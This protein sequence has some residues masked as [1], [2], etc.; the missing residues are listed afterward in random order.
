M[1]NFLPKERIEVQSVG[2]FGA[3]NLAK[4]ISGLMTATQGLAKTIN[5]SMV[6][7]SED[8]GKALA[9]DALIEWKR[10]ETSYNEAR[11]SMGQQFYESVDNQPSA[12]EQTSQ[13]LKM[14]M[15]QKLADVKEKLGS[16]SVAY[17]AFEDHFLLQGTNLTEN[18]KSELSKEHE[19]YAK[20]QLNQSAI[21]QAN[22]LGNDM[23]TENAIALRNST[24]YS[25][26]DDQF[27]KMF[28]DKINGE[29]INSNIDLRPYVIGKKQVDYKNAKNEF[30]KHF[31]SV[32]EMNDDGSITSKVS[33]L[34]QEDIARIKNSWDNRISSIQQANERND[35]FNLENI[36]V[37]Q[38]IKDFIPS[39]DITNDL[40]NINSTTSGLKDSLTA[41]VSSVKPED[42]YK[43][44]VT[45]QEAEN[46]KTDITNAYIVAQ[47]PE[48]VKRT[49]EDGFFRTNTGE[50]ISIDTKYVKSIVQKQYDIKL[51]E[52]VNNKDNP[53]ALK[54]I[55]QDI[56]N[57]QERSGVPSTSIHSMF[58][59][60]ASFSDR[61]IDSISSN[62]DMISLLRDNGYTYANDDVML[63]KD[64]VIKVKQIIDEGRKANKSD[65][66][67]KI[68]LNRFKNSTIASANANKNMDIGVVKN[69]VEKVLTNKNDREEFLKNWF[70]RKISIDNFVG[71]NESIKGGIGGVITP[72]SQ[73]LE[74]S[75]IDYDKTDKDSIVNALAKVSMP[76][77]QSTI[78]LLGDDYTFSL[79]KVENNQLRT[80]PVYTN[81]IVD[82]ANEQ[83]GFSG[84]KAL[85]AKNVSFEYQYDHL[86]QETY[87]NVYKKNDSGLIEPNPI[88]NRVNISKLESFDVKNKVEK[89]KQLIKDRQ[90]EELNNML[91]FGG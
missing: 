13:D 49:L 60:Y 35:Y 38:S 57:Y 9:R 51:N 77:G 50:T 68:E 30:N 59:S 48:T 10:T 81:V 29:F 75:G 83:L 14:F 15:P 89:Q 65:T 17:K 6:S 80:V 12:Y 58:A 31:N 28:V 2:A 74:A 61:S 82:M 5:K 7:E 70:S 84:D 86:N 37:K 53:N 67:I 47:T 8:I 26:T 33:W 3:D 24:K 41:T 85:K 36:K 40:N 56:N 71:F 78:G 18:Y 21:A 54:V 32:A 52:I 20:I 87:I 69:T 11:N 62:A 63:K 27:S 19:Y 66:D 64:S 43:L 76:K 45:A 22:T 39:G 34:Q 55:V 91:G 72:F 4:D 46:L 88:L 73:M 90:Q 42:A 23:G 44:K 25:M 1:A 79:A 16:D